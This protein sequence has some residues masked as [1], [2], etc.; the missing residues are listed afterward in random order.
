MTDGQNGGTDGRTDRTGFINSAIL[1]SRLFGELDLDADCYAD[2]FD[3]EVKRVLDIHSP[4]RLGRRR[5]GEHDS[6]HLSDEA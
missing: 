1:Q 3:A 2:L 5:C 6:C 4:R